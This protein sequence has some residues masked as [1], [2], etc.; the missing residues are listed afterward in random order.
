MIDFSK[1]IKESAA[2]ATAVSARRYPDVTDA[3]I[4][5]VVRKLAER[6]Y[7]PDDQTPK[8][9]RAHLQGRSVLLTGHPGVGKTFLASMLFA[10]RP[11]HAQR[12]IA[13]WGLEGL[14]AWKSYYGDLNITIDDLGSERPAVN[15]GDKAEM[16]SLVIEW[17]YARCSKLRTN[18]TTNLTGEQIG[19]RYGERILDRILGMCEPFTIGGASKR[20]GVQC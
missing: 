19:E 1:L 14:D 12:Q 10:G 13:D 3:A 4:A 11:L 9:V 6:G 8:I 7:V 18:I 17:R 2:R 15:Y 20:R 16:L 5:S